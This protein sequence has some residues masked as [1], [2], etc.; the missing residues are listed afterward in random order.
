MLSA[1]TGAEPLTKLKGAGIALAVTGALEMLGVLQLSLHSKQ[2]VGVLMLMLQSGGYAAFIVS[3]AH[4]LRYDARPLTVFAMACVLGEV[5]LA[6]AAAPYVRGTRWLAVPRL[7][8]LAMLYCGVVVSVFAH[9]TVSWAV[10]HVSAT[11]PSL[12]CCLQPLC[13]SVLAAV[14]YG[15]TLTVREGIGAALIV[16]GMVLPVWAKR[17]QDVHDRQYKRRASK[18]LPRP[19]QLELHQ[20]PARFAA[21]HTGAQAQTPTPLRAVVRE[22]PRDDSKAL[23]ARRPS[24]RGIQSSSDSSKPSGDRLRQSQAQG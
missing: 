18:D 2:S 21:A 4:V 14:V 16:P 6:I 23:L 10:R 22:M 17:K 5:L 20:P 8:W 3:L 19:P 12:Y 13:T 24:S 11:V 7:A 1:A 9:G 15:D